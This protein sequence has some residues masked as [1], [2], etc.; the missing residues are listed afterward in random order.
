MSTSLYE[1]VQEENSF[2]MSSIFQPEEVKEIEDSLEKKLKTIRK[3]LKHEGLFWESRGTF[4]ADGEDSYCLQAAIR[5]ARVMELMNKHSFHHGD[6]L[7]TTKERTET[8]AEGFPGAIA[9]YKGTYSWAPD[10]DFEFTGQEKK[11][12]RTYSAKLM[13]DMMWT[14][15]I[16][17]MK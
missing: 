1:L 12:M 8:F 17:F 4:I 5:V 15:P 3:V 6:H 7:S 14:L 16:H 11:Y 13:N 2:D 9:H 10:G